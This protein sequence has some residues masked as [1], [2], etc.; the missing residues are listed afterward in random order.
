MIRSL[1]GTAA[2]AVLLVSAAPAFA[3]A[4]LTANFDLISKPD[5]GTG[6]LGA[7]TLTQNGADEVDVAVKLSANAAFVSTG[8]AHN[9]FTF[10]L[11]SGLTGYSI[12]IASPSG[13]AFRLAGPIPP[14]RRTARSPPASTAPAA[15]PGPAT[16][17]RDRSIS[18]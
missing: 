18:R 3:D 13:G 15:A 14:T 8:G 2:L 16:R 4:T 6:T 17:S 12:A 1:G 7:V 11:V 9:A 10:N 5:I